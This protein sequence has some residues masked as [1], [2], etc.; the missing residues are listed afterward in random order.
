MTPEAAIIAE[1][2]EER[3]QRMADL[4]INEEDYEVHNS[5]DDL[6]VK[7]TSLPPGES[8]DDEE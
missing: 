7:D 2:V 8:D 5:D 4:G 3:R 1:D 6:P